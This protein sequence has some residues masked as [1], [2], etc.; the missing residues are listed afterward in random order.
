MNLLL[1][2]N[3]FSRLIYNQL[4]DELKNKVQF[5]P[6]SVIASKL[7][8]TVEDIGLISTADIIQHKDLFISSKHGISFEGEV[9]NSFLYFAKEDKELNE[10]YLNGD[11]SSLEVI[12]SKI[13]FKEVHDIDVQIHLASDINLVHKK[14]VIVVGDKNYEQGLFSNGLSFS[15]EIIDMIALPYVNFV[16]ASNSQDSL[17][18]LNKVLEGLEEKIYNS[19]END[20]YKIKFSGESNN[21]IKDNFQSVIFDFNEQ[22]VEGITQLTRLPYYYGIASDIIDIK[23]V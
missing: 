18:D 19:I 20:E 8:E 15:S 23:W 21:F 11:I 7:K 12:F 9:S 16:F 14:N 13:Y 5:H 1:P 6:S 3:I 22:D 4:G 10:I 17:E 2:D